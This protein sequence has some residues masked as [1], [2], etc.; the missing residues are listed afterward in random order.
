MWITLWIC[1]KI[2]WKRNYPGIT[3]LCIK[4]HKGMHVGFNQTF[5]E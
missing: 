4:S 1:V 3:E 2:Q 5:C